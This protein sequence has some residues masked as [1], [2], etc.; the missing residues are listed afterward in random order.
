MKGVKP[1][2][3]VEEKNGESISESLH[4][5]SEERKIETQH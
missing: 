4:I 3:L 5:V 2:G 1:G